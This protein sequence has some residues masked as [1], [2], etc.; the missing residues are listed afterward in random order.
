MNS[1]IKLFKLE[2]FVPYQTLYFRRNI[3][4]FFNTNYLVLPAKGLVIS[5]KN[6]KMIKKFY[7]FK[8]KKIGLNNNNFINIYFDDYKDLGYGF[9]FF[10]TK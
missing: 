9:N 5:N 4:R 1:F 8:Y 7:H 6:F 10:N 3:L 2:F